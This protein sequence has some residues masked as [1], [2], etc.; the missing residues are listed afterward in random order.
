[1]PDDIFNISNPD[2]FHNACIETFLFQYEHSPVYRQ[3]ID[4]MEVGPDQVNDI[5]Q[6]PFLPISFFKTHQII[7]RNKDAQITFSSSGTSGMSFSRHFVADK[8]LY[9]KSFNKGFEHFYGSPEDYCFLALLP[10]YF[11]RSGSSLIYMMDDLI[12]RSRYSE[13]GF[14]LNELKELSS[15][16]ESLKK[17]KTPTI[18]FG[19][20]Y[21]LLDLA[22]AFPMDLSQIIVMETGGMKG[23]RPEISKGQLHKKLYNSFNIQEV[24]SEYGMTEL[25]S[26]A[27]SS[28]NGKFKTPP[29][30]RILI[31]DP[32]DPLS[33]MKNGK[34]GGINI[35][36]LANKY[37]CAF[38]QTDDLGRKHPDNSFEIQ[39]RYDSSDLRGCNLLV[40]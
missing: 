13:S 40:Q 26:Q 29:W 32:Y 27:Y 20:S 31:R 4:L 24:H 37:S 9:L 34:T 25:L 33:Y 28:G 5:N 14:Y 21:A 18:L 23:N 39:G 7:S 19:V 11:E 16:L 30:M 35:I 3:Y 6:I 22:E 38:I 8:S 36:D 2:E 1:M 17:N 10:S 12:N 15:A